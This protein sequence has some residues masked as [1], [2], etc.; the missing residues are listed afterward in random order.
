MSAGLPAPEPPAERPAGRALLALHLVSLV[1]LP[2]NLWEPGLELS[3]ETSPRPALAQPQALSHQTEE[4]Q[5]LSGGMLSRAE[6]SR[7]EIL[8]YFIFRGIL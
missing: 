3:Q 6:L 2:G 5:T 1:R 7:A 4:T 8:L